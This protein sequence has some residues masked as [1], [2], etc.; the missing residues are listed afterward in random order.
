MR[1]P[2][3]TKHSQ[4]ADENLKLDL[5][6]SWNTIR[7]ENHC[8]HR[9]FIINQRWIL[10]FSCLYM[11]FIW[12]G[13]FFYRDFNESLSWS[14]VFMW[15]QWTQKASPKDPRLAVNWSRN[16]SQIVGAALLNP[17][18]L[19]S[20]ASVGDVC[21]TSRW[22]VST[23]LRCRRGLFADAVCDSS[24]LH[25]ILALRGYNCRRILLSNKRN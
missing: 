7:A 20:F 6:S 12:S 24:R 25:A 11:S 22:N 10:Q 4:R 3:N 23:R 9:T 19:R 16:W 17:I 18:H 1:W 8:D 13:F 15:S 21:A 2:S 14:L 5:K